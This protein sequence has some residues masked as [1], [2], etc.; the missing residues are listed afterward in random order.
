MSTKGIFEKVSFDSNKMCH[1][2]EIETQNMCFTVFINQNP[3][4]GGPYYIL[5]VHFMR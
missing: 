2:L 3:D 5:W 4:G 1:P